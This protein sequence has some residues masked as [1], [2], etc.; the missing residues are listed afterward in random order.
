MARSC[1]PDLAKILLVKIL[2]RFFLG[3]I[4]ARFIFKKSL[5]VIKSDLVS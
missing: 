5:F 2:A 1:K 3:K 4:W